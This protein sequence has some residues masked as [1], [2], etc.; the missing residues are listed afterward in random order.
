MTNQRNH[1][2]FL[3]LFVFHIKILFSQFLLILAA[4][5]VMAEAISRIMSG[6]QEEVVLF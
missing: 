5:D 2:S 1:W 6:E 3:L 4:K